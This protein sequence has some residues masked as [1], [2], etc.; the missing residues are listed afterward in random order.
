MGMKII[1]VIVEREQNLDVLA[2]YQDVRCRASMETI[3]AAL[4][5]NDRPEHVF[6][7]VSEAMAL[8]E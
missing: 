2:S 4:N 8:H 6:A 1:R 7:L 3:K 5:G